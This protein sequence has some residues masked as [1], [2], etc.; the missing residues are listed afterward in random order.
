VTDLRRVYWDANAWLGLINRE[1]NKVRALEIVY[2]K[3]KKNDIE[4]WTST[5]SF[6]EVYKMKDDPAAPRSLEEQ[7]KIIAAV[8]E[9]QFVQLVEVNQI[10]GMNARDLLQKHPALKKPYDAIHLASAA[11]WNLHALHTYDNV[12]LLPLNGQVK[13]R[14]GRVLEII[15]PDSDADGPLFGGGSGQ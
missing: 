11:H 2:E 4:I 1:A 5:I 12:N 9:Q 15:K 14:D 3:A 6:A 13:R 7:N 8:L 10:I